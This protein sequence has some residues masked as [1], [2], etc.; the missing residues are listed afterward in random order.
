MQIELQH[1]IKIFSSFKQEELQQLSVIAQLSS[2][3]TQ[4]LVNTLLTDEVIKEKKL[5]LIISKWKVPNLAALYKETLELLLGILASRNKNVQQKIRTNI[6]NIRVLYEHHQ[7]DLCSQLIE[8]TRQIILDNDEFESLNDLLQWDKILTLYNTQH[9]KD[10]NKVIRGQTA[11][12]QQ[13]VNLWQYRELSLKTIEWDGNV[14][15]RGDRVKRFKRLLN[16]PLLKDENEALSTTAKLLHHTICTSLHRSLENYPQAHAHYKRMLEI[17]QHTQLNESRWEA[18][19]AT[20]NNYANISLFL[21]W[22]DDALM[23]SDMLKQY[24]RIY[25]FIANRNME[26]DIFIRAYFI[27]IQVYKETLEFEKGMALLPLINEH[28]SKPNQPIKSMYR[29][30]IIYEMAEL[31][32]LCG[33]Y[34]ATLQYLK[35]LFNF[36]LQINTDSQIMGKMLELLTYVELNKIKDLKKN[37][38]S[39]KSYMKQNNIKSRYE[40]LFVD[41]MEKIAACYPQDETDNIQISTAVYQEYL[42]LFKSINHLIEEDAYFDLVSWLA[43]KVQNKSI[44][45]I[46]NQKRK[47]QNYMAA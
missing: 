24:P 22:Y 11:I 38:A 30:G 10:I 15:V 29:M 5:R 36:N 41:L 31:S 46:L 32:F 21:K 16:L 47:D 37:I 17:Y 20:I 1:I 9:Q 7:F 4:E 28:L 12:C 8:T 44:V 13:M 2:T 45:D 40:V 33:N 39:T 42:D 6:A 27:E 18:F 34:E 14:I 26:S 23:V 19:V 3:H 43:A 25:P 35:S